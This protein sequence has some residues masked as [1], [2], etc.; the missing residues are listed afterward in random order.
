FALPEFVSLYIQ[1]DMH[2]EKVVFGSQNV[3]GIGWFFWDS[4]FGRFFNTGPIVNHNGNIWFFMHTFLWAFLPWTLFFLFGAIADLKARSTISQNEKENLVFLLGSFVPTFV[5]FSATKFQLDHYI[6]ILLPFCAILTAHYIIK[7]TLKIVSLVQI[8]ISLLLI[9]LAVTLSVK[10]LPPF[11]TAALTILSF[12]VIFFFYLQR[13]DGLKQKSITLAVSSTLIVII[14]VTLINSIVY[15]KYNAGYHM[16][17]F[18][19]QKPH[20]PVY[21]YKTYSF[22][23]EMDYTGAHKR[24]MDINELV[25]VAKPYYILTD[26][27][28]LGEIKEEYKI[29]GTFNNIIQDRFIISMLNEKKFKENNKTWLLLEIR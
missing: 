20:L 15:A 3:S 24:V 25:N 12:G 26:K 14:C 13:K 27:D 23:L 9:T 17:R 21:G 1:F 22:S 6:N 11:W 19:N 28:F 2:P 18:L 29:I 16:A 4:Q 5:L 10:M 7:H 8:A